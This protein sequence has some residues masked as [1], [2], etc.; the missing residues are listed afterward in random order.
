M[1]VSC[2]L[3]AEVKGGVL[4]ESYL[5]MILPRRKTKPIEDYAVMLLLLG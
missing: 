1:L 2:L 5:K 3:P 4:N